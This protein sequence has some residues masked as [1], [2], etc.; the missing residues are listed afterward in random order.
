[1]K[2]IRLIDVELPEFGV[3]SERP[4]LTS[5]IYSER[6]ARLGRLMQHNGLSALIVYA[7]REHSANI[8]YLTEFEPRFE[9]ALLILAAG[10]RPVIM[11]GPENHGWP[12]N[13]KAPIEVEMVLY[14]PFGLL[15]QDQRRAD[16]PD[17]ARQRAAGVRPLLLGR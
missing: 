15:G 10:K 8:A 9:E 7:D 3:P 6:L 2:E 13:G 5:R 1:M 12:G 14:P 16:V 11:T 17:A 4:N